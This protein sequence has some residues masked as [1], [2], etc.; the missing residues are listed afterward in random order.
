[1]TLGAQARRNLL[2]AVKEALSNG[3]RHAEART[4]LLR[5]CLQ[6][7]SLIVEVADDGHGF[8]VAKGR[9]GGKGLSNIKGR[10]EI[11]NGRAEIK[12]PPGGGT[13]VTLSLPLPNTG[14]NP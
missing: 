12:S 1:L 10:M 5:L 2:L 7:N 4:I 8:D 13:T 11:L 3:V 9:A 6:D 14:A